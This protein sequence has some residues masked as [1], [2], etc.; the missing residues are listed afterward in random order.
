MYLNSS[1]AAK[2][3]NLINGSEVNGVAVSMAFNNLK[4]EQVADVRSGG[5]INSKQLPLSQRL[6]SA[7]IIEEDV[8]DAYKEELEPQGFGRDGSYHDPSDSE[9]AGLEKEQDS[10]PEVEIRKGDNGKLNGRSKISPYESSYMSNGHRH[11]DSESELLNSPAKSKEEEKHSSDI[12]GLNKLDGTYQNLKLDDRI[13]LE[14]QSIGLYPEPVRFILE[15]H[16]CVYVLFSPLV[17]SNSSPM[18]LK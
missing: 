14:L 7:L 15:L 18:C 10:E 16:F 12:N 4:E 1:D 3:T 9:Q 5:W 11:W 13:A 8:D 17:W 2:V 6:L